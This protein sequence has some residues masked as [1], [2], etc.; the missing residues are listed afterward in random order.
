MGEL[1]MRRH[2]DVPAGWLLTTSGCGS[3]G[4]ICCQSGQIIVGALLGLVAVTAFV[5]GAA[6]TR[7]FWR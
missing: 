6:K 2:I 3:M 5:M 1:A 4:A 7:V